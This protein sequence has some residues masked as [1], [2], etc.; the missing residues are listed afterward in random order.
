MAIEF[1][2]SFPPKNGRNISP[3][4]VTDLATK[5]GLNTELGVLR[6]VANTKGNPPEIHIRA[7]TETVR[8]AIEP[9]V[10]A[11]GVLFQFSPE[12]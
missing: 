2:I 6:A 3:D 11:Q 10:Q 1:T 12:S 9:L 4:F 8:E 5:I 7:T